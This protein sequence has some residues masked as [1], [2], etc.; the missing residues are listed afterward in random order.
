[1]LRPLLSQNVKIRKH[2]GDA[3]D[4]ENGGGRNLENKI[5]RFA[6]FFSHKKPLDFAP[7]P[8]HRLN[9]L[10]MNFNISQQKPLGQTLYFENI[11]HAVTVLGCHLPRR[12]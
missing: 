8:L 2:Q 10:Y 11:F 7:Q 1:M 3:H 6:L 12:R 4:E 5:Y 9:L